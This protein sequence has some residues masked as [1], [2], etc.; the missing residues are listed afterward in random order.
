MSHSAYRC[1]V[2]FHGEVDVAGAHKFAC[3]NVL[4]GI[5]ER[6]HSHVFAFKRQT[7][8]QSEVGH[9]QSALK[10]SAGFAVGEVV[11]VSHVHLGEVAGHGV[12]QLR[13]YGKNL[14]FEQ[15]GLVPISFEVDVQVSFGVLADFHPV[16]IVAETAQIGVEPSGQIVATLFHELFFLAS[17]SQVL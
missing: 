16:G 8:A 13:Y 17:K 1:H 3:F 7:A 9:Y 15:H 4:R 14:H 2:V 6:L 10:H 12:V 11:V 5:D